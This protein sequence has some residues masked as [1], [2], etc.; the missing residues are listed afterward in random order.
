MFV[1]TNQLDEEAQLNNED[2]A[3]QKWRDRVKRLKT[4]GLSVPVKTEWPRVLRQTH[5]AGLLV[6]SVGFLGLAVWSSILATRFSLTFDFAFYGQAWYLI[7]HGHL[8][9]F[10]TVANSFFWQNALELFMWPIACL[11]YVWPH[12]VTL[13]WLQDAA[14]AATE[15]LLFTWM[16]EVTAVAFKAKQLKDWYV[17]FPLAGLVLLVANPWT[18]WI[19]SF[20]FHPESI[21]LF[22]AI[23]MARAFWQ[24]R[25][26]RGWTTTALT[27]LGGAL[28]ATYV[29]GVGISA[30][31]A[32]RKWR[33]IGIPLAVIGFTYLVF[34]AAVGGNKAGGEVYLNLVTGSHLRTVTPLAIARAIIEHPTRA[35]SAIW[36]VRLD[37]LANI[38]TGGIVGLLNPWAFGIVLL[39]LIEGSLTGLANYAQPYVQ[40]SL[41][42]ALLMPL[43]TMMVCLAF[44]TS[45]RRWLKPIGLILVVLVVANAIGWSVVWAPRVESQFAR[46]SPGAVDS[47]SHALAAIPSNDEVIVSQG[48]AGRFALRQWIYPIVADPPSTFPIHTRV[49]WFVVVP[50]QGIE[51]ESTQGAD[52]ELDQIANRLHARLVSDANG[53][54]IF[55]WI[56]PSREGTV[57]FHPM[58]IVPAWTL[59]TGAS[60]PLT[61]G[62][63]I[64]WHMEA[65][66]EPGYVVWGDFWRPKAGP[67]TA[68][69][70]FSS[71]G[72]FDVQVWNDTTGQLL[73]GAKFGSTHGSIETRSISGDLKFGSSTPAYAGFGPFTV[74]PT[75]PPPGNVI[76]IRVS[77]PGG[78]QISLYS[79]GLG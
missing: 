65:T 17:V 54:F 73:I 19:N 36:A 42:V 47:L 55:R 4:E 56:P 51:T 24:G 28:G 6:I 46:V 37:I 13:L 76:E 15:A 44:S 3:H 40:N 31:L 61:T 5:I 58:T 57:T 35:L 41:P 14:T 33:K 12:A 68:T 60:K 34:I 62:P 79:V 43:G 30:Y 7:A 71:S 67:V 50:N 11:W 70:K 48:V 59:S 74:H 2:A 72:S 53:V 64:L 8:D 29:V 20:D 22:A 52:A 78:S 66:G 69:L 32:G 49:I 10:S 75:E 18:L 9:P 1:V 16:C 23:F 45:R 21:D 77:T 27:L 26:R 39:T 63:P 25:N 38:S